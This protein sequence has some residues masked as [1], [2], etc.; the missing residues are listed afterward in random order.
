MAATADT[1]DTTNTAP[2]DQPSRGARVGALVGEAIADLANLCND[3]EN[4]AHAAKFVAGCVER[5]R[6][7]APERVAWIVIYSLMCCFHATAKKIHEMLDAEALEA[8]KRGE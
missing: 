6:F 8:I 1:N 4:R 5:G 7:V 2:A 3:P